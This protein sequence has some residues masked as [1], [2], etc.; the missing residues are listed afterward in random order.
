M[1]AYLNENQDP[2]GSLVHYPPLAASCDLWTNSSSTDT[3]IC[4]SAHCNVILVFSPDRIM[5]G[6]TDFDTPRS[7]W[8]FAE[9][10]KDNIRLAASPNQRPL[11]NCGK[12]GDVGLPGG[13]AGGCRETDGFGAIAVGVIVF[14]MEQY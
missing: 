5:P 9:L 13:V 6:S 8:T 1:F 11:S 7:S 12:D 4:V 14:V 2:C 3:C 10:G